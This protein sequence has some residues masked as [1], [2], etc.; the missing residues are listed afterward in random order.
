MYVFDPERPPKTPAVK[1][2]YM[3]R[4]ISGRKCCNN[5]FI[6]RNA[7]TVPTLL[8]CNQTTAQYVL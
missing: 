2:I 7:A 5:T 6:T 8:M 4:G 3:S 1:P